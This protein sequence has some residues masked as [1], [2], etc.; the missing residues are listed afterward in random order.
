MCAKA[1]EL[2][3]FVS[4]GLDFMLPLSVTRTGTN[5]QEKLKNCDSITGRLLVAN[6]NVD[7]VTKE[8]ELRRTLTAL[9]RKRVIGCET[10]SCGTIRYYLTRIPLPP[11]VPC[12]RARNR[13]DLEIER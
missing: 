9:L 12:R 5:P 13:L 10:D 2:L 6:P 8:A 11:R 7:A 1:S 4:A 3:D